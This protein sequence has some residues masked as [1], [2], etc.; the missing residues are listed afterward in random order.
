MKSIDLSE[1]QATE[2]G[3]A[4]VRW[5]T[6][7]DPAGVARLLAGLDPQTTDDDRA[8]AIGRAVIE[9]LVVEETLAD[10]R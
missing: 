2:F 7:D 10:P 1:E 6:D 9:D 8:A 5:V 4:L 3:H